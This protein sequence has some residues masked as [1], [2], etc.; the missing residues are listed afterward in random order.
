MTKLLTLL[1]IITALY[2]IAIPLQADAAKK[3]KVQSDKERLVLMPIRVPVDDKNLTG[4]MET[5]LLEGLQQKYEVFSGEKVAQKAKEIFLKESRNTSRTEC[6]E[7]RCMQ[8]I[9]EAFQAE[10][11]ATANVSKQDGGYFLALK[12][13][14]IFDNKAVYSKSIPCRGCDSFQVIDKL[15]ELSGGEID[16][17]ITTQVVASAKPA[18]PQKAISQKFVSQG[19]LTWMQLNDSGKK[20]PDAN[21][22]CNNTAVNGQTGWRLP[23]EVELESFYNSGATTWV[24]GYSWSSTPGK[25]G[26]RDIAGHYIV[27]LGYGGVFATPD[28]GIFGVTCVHEGA[29]QS[30]LPKGFISQGGLTWMPV[31]SSRKSWMDANDYCNNTA[32]NGQKD[33]RLPTKEELFALYTS[34]AMKDQGWILDFTWSYTLNSNGGHYG[35][36]LNS[37]RADMGYDTMGD[38]VTCI[39]TN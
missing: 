6:D 25:V 35:V 12:I 11:I 13:E 2:L 29:T 34:D 26:G 38:Y 23:T 24:F 1:T 18:Q 20:W 14:N 3:Q 19:G 37:G 36:N 16:P 30:E 9:A 10:L 33:W 31:T 5:A 17:A 28:T 7:T 15:K 27:T 8:N 32:I 4:A 21:A 22:Y 39:H